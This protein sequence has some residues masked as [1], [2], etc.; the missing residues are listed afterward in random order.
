MFECVYII[1]C[2]FWLSS[3][4]SFRWFQAL[5]RWHDITAMLPA[6]VNIYVSVRNDASC[7]H[8]LWNTDNWSKSLKFQYI[9]QWNVKCKG[10]ERHNVKNSNTE[11]RQYNSGL[12]GS[13]KAEDMVKIFFTIDQSWSLKRKQRQLK[14]QRVAKMSVSAFR[15]FNEFHYEGG[16]TIKDAAIVAHPSR[17]WPCLDGQ[18]IWHTWYIFIFDITHLFHWLPITHDLWPLLLTWFNFNL[19][20]D[21]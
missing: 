3:L 20:M 10:K 18:N 5:C 2:I 13:F 15:M 21:K 6:M 17:P 16:F 8:I 14:V 4:K 12:V 11:N 19:S 7:S 9:W 1:F